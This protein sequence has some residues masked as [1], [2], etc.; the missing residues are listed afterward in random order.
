MS[1]IQDQQ[2]LSKLLRFARCMR[3]H[4]VPDWP[5]P[6]TNTSQGQPI[7][8]LPGSINPDS[9]QVNTAVNECLSLLPTQLHGNIP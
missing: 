8:N 1:Q 3:S 5:D 7:F 4:A 2:A 9:P 6:T